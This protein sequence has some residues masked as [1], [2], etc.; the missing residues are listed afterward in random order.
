MYIVKTRKAKSRRGKCKI[1]KNKYFAFSTLPFRPSLFDF[2][3]SYFGPKEY[4][5]RKPEMVLTGH[6][7]FITLHLSSPNRLIQRMK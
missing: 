3:I 5:G 2:T 7:S 4:E 1:G 6:H